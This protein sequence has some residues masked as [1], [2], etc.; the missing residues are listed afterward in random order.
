MADE[1]SPKVKTKFAARQKL[2][3]AS[4]KNF[5]HGSNSN[6]PEKLSPLTSKLIS[7]TAHT[8]RQSATERFLD[9][10]AADE[11]VFCDGTTR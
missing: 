3:G 7:T 11:P 10:R 2:S 5:T 6:F 9:E 4:A 8:A 1:A